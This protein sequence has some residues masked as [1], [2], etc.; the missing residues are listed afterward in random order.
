M[1]SLTAML[2]KQT[3]NI[4]VSVFKHKI[5]YKI[6]IDHEAIRPVALQSVTVKN[7]YITMIFGADNNA[8]APPTRSATFA[9]PCGYSFIAHRVSP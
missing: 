7:G 6:P 9:S 3:R 8:D 5:E 2:W 4:E 1:K